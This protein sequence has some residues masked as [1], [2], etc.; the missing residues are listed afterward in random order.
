MS[1]RMVSC[2]IASNNE[3]RHSSEIRLKHGIS[4]P[5][6]NRTQSHLVAYQKEHE[7]DYSCSHIWLDRYHD[8]RLHL[9]CDDFGFPS[10]SKSE[11]S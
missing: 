11:Y 1:I 4:V 7:S 9:G 5:G 2:I 10:W 3:T 8:I 6:T